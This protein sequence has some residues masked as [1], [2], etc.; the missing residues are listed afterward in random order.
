MASAV[1]VST[2]D[3]IA[4]VIGRPRND[5][6]CTD[7]KDANG[8]IDERANMPVT[9][10]NLEEEA[11][12]LSRM[13]AEQSNC[14]SLANACTKSISEVRSVLAKPNFNADDALNDLDAVKR[15]LIQAHKSRSLWPVLFVRIFIY[16]LFLMIG[17]VAV[18][19]W[20]SLIPD[21]AGA[22]SGMAAGILACAIWG[23]VGGVV[24]AFV[25]L[26]AHFTNQDFDN[27]FQPWYYLHP[28]LG[29][30]LGAIIYLVFQ[31]G[32]SAIS[33]STTGTTQTMQVGVTAL[34]IA[35]A[36]FAGFKQTSAMEFLGRIVKSVFQ[37]DDST[38]KKSS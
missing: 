17:F 5:L 19:V 2:D 13:A 27:Q 16:N 14:I 6:I 29:M 9:R 35:V 21:N 10:S 36:F 26:I 4:K 24:D 18:I 23:G 33:N 30:S 32:L 8:N 11:D 20:K 38:D 37:K 34:S 22:S 25:A 12:R 3:Y 28:L 31:S 7:K 1:P 15:H